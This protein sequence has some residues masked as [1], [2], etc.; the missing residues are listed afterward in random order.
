MSDTNSSSPLLGHLSVERFM[1]EYWQKKPCIIRRAL[2]VDLIQHLS[3]DEIAGLSMEEEIESRL[4]QG[5]NNPNSDN[6]DPASAW[7]VKHGP[8]DEETLINLPDQDWTILIQ[9]VDLLLEE[10]QSFL[11]WVSFIPRWRLDDLMVSLAAPGGGVG[12]HRDQYDVFLIQAQ[13]QKNWKVAKPSALPDIFPAEDLAQVADFI[14]E[15]DEVFDVGD[16]LYL[17]PGWLHSGT[18]I[19]ESITCSIGF[20]APSAIDLIETVAELF[21]ESSNKQDLEKKYRF[22][23]ALRKPSSSMAI[24]QDDID[25]ARQQLIALIANDEVVARSIA[26]NT[27]LPKIWPDV[28]DSPPTSI[29]FSQDV[30]FQLSPSS[31]MSYFQT[32]NTIEICINSEIYKIPKLNLEILDCLASHQ[33]LMLNICLNNRQLQNI[34]SILIGEGAAFLS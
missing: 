22:G 25:E 10:Y 20:R 17:P 28:P 18:A 5:S 23:D 16:V 33:P 2:S 32:K 12:P 15:I 8:F 21:A 13:G 30:Y 34:V 11:D 4:I 26:I 6:S 31:R 19:T 14:P 27:T 1:A 9:S 3:A 7:Q 29:D 24:N